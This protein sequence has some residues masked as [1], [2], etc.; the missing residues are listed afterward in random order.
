M[1]IVVCKD[2][3]L[4]DRWEA[5]VLTML[6]GE[7]EKKVTVRLPEKPFRNGT[8]RG[9][10]IE[11][12]A[13]TVTDSLYGVVLTGQVQ[14]ILDFRAKVAELALDIKTRPLTMTQNCWEM[15][16]ACREFRGDIGADALDAYITWRSVVR[17]MNSFADGVTTDDTIHPEPKEQPNTEEQAAALDNLRKASRKAAAR[18]GLTA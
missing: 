1:R 2:M 8:F 16:K 13:N 15:E 9:S 12:V 5:I 7:E 10:V 18:N 14:T 4:T 6:E 3:A 11:R 17:I